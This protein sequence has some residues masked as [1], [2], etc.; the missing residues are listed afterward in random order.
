MRRLWEIWSSEL[1]PI[2]ELRMLA[3]H[4]TRFWSRFIGTVEGEMSVA[5]FLVDYFRCAPPARLHSESPLIIIT[6][7][8]F[9]MAA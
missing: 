2:G 7:S 8:S 3:L 9:S 4:E 1:F 6:A 5:N